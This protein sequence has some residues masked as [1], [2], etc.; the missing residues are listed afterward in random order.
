MLAPA[1]LIV[2]ALAVVA[3]FAVGTSPAGADTW[4][5]PDSGSHTGPGGFDAWAF[6]VSATGGQ[7][8]ST[9]QRCEF[10]PEVSPESGPVP[11]HYEYVVS[12]IRPGEYMVTLACVPDDE[13]LDRWANGVPMEEWDPGIFWWLVDM[14]TVTAAD[15]E[16]LLAQALA[17]LDPE[18][19]A[20][21]TNPTG[22]V[23]SM[24]RIPTWFWLEGGVPSV[25]ETITDGPLAVTVTATPVSVSWD[26]GDG[27]SVTCRDEANVGSPDTDT[28]SHTYETSSA[29]QPGR[30]ARGRPAYTVAAGI[31]YVGSYEVTLWGV[32]VGGAT[33]IGGIVRVSE[34]PLAVNEAQ[35]V[36]R[37]T[38]R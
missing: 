2:G 24:V 5:P 3:A 12:E 8:S 25:S 11:A 21:G 20:I 33:D 36:N 7:G 35:A 38:R 9:T 19:P 29:G 10:P 28:C 17:H 4:E 34:V 30:D 31:E 18:P 26:A 1:R 22:G 13:V 32:P 37:P 23:A 6:W 14:W 15:P 27:G 16:D